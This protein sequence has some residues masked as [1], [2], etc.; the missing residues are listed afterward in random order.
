MS[1]NH[2]RNNSGTV[3]CIPVTYKGSALFPPLQYSFHPLYL[4]IPAAGI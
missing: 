3:I 4:N 1:E 2:S